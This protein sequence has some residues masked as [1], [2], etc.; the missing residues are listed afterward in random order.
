MVLLE[1]CDWYLPW[2]LT[3]ISTLPFFITP[4][5]EYV[6]P[7]SIP[8]TGPWTW[9]ASSDFMG[10]WSSAFAGDASI[11]PATRTRRRYRAMLHVERWL[12]DRRAIVD[13]M[14]GDNEDCGRTPLLKSVLLC[15]VEQKKA[16]GIK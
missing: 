4:T 13:V 12:V 8:M 10:S 7:R 1:R 3:I 9:E 5:Q 2:S 6:V 15:G 14:C 16:P 11:K